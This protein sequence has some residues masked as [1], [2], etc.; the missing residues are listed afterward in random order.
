MKKI[1]C[2]VMTLC[3]LVFCSCSNTESSK[4]SE[5]KINTE[6]TSPA[7]DENNNS[8]ISESIDVKDDAQEQKTPVNTK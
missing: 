8:E 6:Q 4:K 2:F 5:N 3:M 7:T 1:F